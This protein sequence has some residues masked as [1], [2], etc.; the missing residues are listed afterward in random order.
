[1]KTQVTSGP[2][3]VRGVD[4]IDVERRRVYFRAGG[5]DAARD[6]YF[7][8]QAVAALEQ[9][10]LVDEELAAEREM[11]ELAARAQSA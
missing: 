3:A 6:P 11:R 7:V 1:M 5:I 10:G 9:E 8:H 2:W 4:K